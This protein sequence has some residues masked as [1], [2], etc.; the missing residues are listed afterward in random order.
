MDLLTSLRIFFIHHIF[1]FFVDSQ[2]GHSLES[3]NR[4]F[5][6]GRQK[7]RQALQLQQRF[8]FTLEISVVLLLLFRIL[9]LLSTILS[10]LGRKDSLACMYA[11]LA[12]FWLCLGYMLNIMEISFIFIFPFFRPFGA[13]FVVYW[14]YVITYIVLHF[15]LAAGAGTKLGSALPI[16]LTS[17]IHDP[18]EVCFVAQIGAFREEVHFAN[19]FVLGVGSVICTWFSQDPPRFQRWLAGDHAVRSLAA[20][21]HWYAQIALRSEKLSPRILFFQCASYRY[22]SLYLGHISTLNVIICCH[23]G[24]LLLFVFYFFTSAIRRRF[25]LWIANDSHKLESQRLILDFISM[26]LQGQIDLILHW[27][28]GTCTCV[29]GQSASLPLHSGPLEAERFLRQF[30]S[31]LYGLRAPRQAQHRLLVRAVA[32]N[33]HSAVVSPGWIFHRVKILLSHLLIFH[34]FIKVFFGFSLPFDPLLMSWRI[35]FHF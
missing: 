9:R 1:C 23:L 5:V 14:R 29:L 7:C 4:I 22:L 12:R 25:S 21:A 2:N 8:S 11:M 35:I 20:F 32:D 31:V 3:S 28:Q 33:L 19:V 13:V 15:R 26:M 10:Q 6:Y 18:V 24:Y 27:W 17:Q 34:I 16:F 30:I